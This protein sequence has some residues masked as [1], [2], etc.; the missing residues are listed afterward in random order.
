MTD[1]IVYPRKPML[2]AD[3]EDGWKYEVTVYPIPESH[4]KIADAIRAAIKDLE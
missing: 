2:R 4:I 3:G 1:V